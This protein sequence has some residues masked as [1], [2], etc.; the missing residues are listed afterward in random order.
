MTRALATF[1]EQGIKAQPVACD[2]E[3]LPVMEAEG[4]AFRLVPAIEHVKTLTLYVHEVIGW[5]YY[6]ARG[7]I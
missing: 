5:Y 4:S 1:E 3:G 2:F 6:A 7:W